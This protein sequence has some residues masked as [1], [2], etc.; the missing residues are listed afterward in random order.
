[1]KRS[2][3]YKALKKRDGQHSLADAV[4]W[5]KHQATA[6]FDESIDVA[7]SLNIKKKHTIRDTVVFPHA[8]GIAPKVLVFAKEKKAE[9]AKKAGAD[10]V[11]EN[12]LIEKIQKGWMDFEV[13]IAT[14]DMMKTVAKI[15]RAL[16]TKGL[17]PNPKAKTVTENVKEAVREVKAG[18]REFRANPEG[19]VNFSVGK[20]SMNDDH[21]IK[22]ILSFVSALQKKKPNDIKG[23]Y[24]KSMHLTSSMGVAVC[25]DR[26][27]ILGSV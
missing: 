16:G 21:L 27:L 2:K 17:M 11:G 3:R 8:F 24:F 22:N 4:K 15:A 10:F 20:K 1:M 9:E 7:F 5:V 13:A 19:I 14:P 25:L 26:K 6:R 23:D 18:R 12:D